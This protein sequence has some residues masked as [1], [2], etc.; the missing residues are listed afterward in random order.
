MDRRLTVSMLSGETI[1][2]DTGTLRSRRHVD[3]PSRTC[4]VNPVIYPKGPRTQIT[5]VLEPK[6]FNVNG[7]WSQKP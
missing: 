4:V 1:L 5:G 2:S 7:I 6:Y 3:S